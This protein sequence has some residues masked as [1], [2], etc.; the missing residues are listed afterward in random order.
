MVNAIHQLVT[1]ERLSSTFFRRNSISKSSYSFFLPH[2]HMLVKYLCVK[3]REENERG[4]EKGKRR[5][6]VERVKWREEEGRPVE[7][8]TVTYTYSSMSIHGI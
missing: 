6:G 3:E 1:T 2:A 5:E 4:K 7:S 8:N